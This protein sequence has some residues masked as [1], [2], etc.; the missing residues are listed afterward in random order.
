MD[1]INEAI[2]VYPLGS[3]TIRAYG[4]DTDAYYGRK[5]PEDLLDDIK[6]DIRR[7]KRFVLLSSNQFIFSVAEKNGIVSLPTWMMPL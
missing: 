7:Q 3:E 6:L 2:E 5:Y 4:F 1:V